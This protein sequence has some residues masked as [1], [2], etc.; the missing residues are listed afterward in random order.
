MVA[1]SASFQVGQSKDAEP[2][3]PAGPTQAPS[4]A[5]AVVT[6]TKRGPGRPPDLAKRR[7]VVD[8]TLAVLAEV[9]YG[10]LTID[11]VARR[12]GSTRVF[13]YRVWESKAGLVADALFGS[14]ADLTV[15]DTGST[16]DDL[17]DHIA[18][19]VGTMSRPAYLNGV[20]GLT[21]DMLRNPSGWREIRSRYIVP[22]EEALTTILERGR[23]RGD[24]VAAVD[25]R[26]ITY[27]VSGTITSL[28]QGL[29]LQGDDLV[30]AVLAAV[31][32]GIVT[33]D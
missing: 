17:R 3:R 23:A 22:A 1:T 10:S 26:V 29:R 9:G 8:A 19:L 12:S 5:S 14:A 30:D 21:V 15:A 31:T 28:A 7:A 2:A 27:V 11:E 18:Q 20:P 6:E 4:V 24:V 32:G 16:R 33:L 13:V 25:V